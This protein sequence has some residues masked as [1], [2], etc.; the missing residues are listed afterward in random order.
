MAAFAAIVFIGLLRWSALTP[1]S[2]GRLMFPCIAAFG[3]AWVYGLGAL[4]R[5]LP[6][7]ATAALACLALVVPTTVLIPAYAK[8]A[9]GWSERLPAPV[10]AVYAGVIE[11]VE[12]G[13]ETTVEPGGEITLRL[14]WRVL[15][16]PAVNYSVFVHLVDDEGVIVA[17]RDMHPGQGSLATAE[18]PPGRLWS[19]RYSLRVSS[20]E[21]APRN[22]HWEIGLYDAASGA[23]AALTRVPGRDNAVAFGANRITPRNNPPVLLQYETGIVL[24]RY[25]LS[26]ST[27]APGEAL[28]VNLD[29]SAS[30]LV[31]G[32]V[33]ASVQLLDARSGKAA[34]SDMPPAGRSTSGWQAGENRADPRTLTIDPGTQSGA[35]RLMLVVYR[36][37][38]F[39]RVG[40]Y[41]ARGIYIGDQIELTRIWIK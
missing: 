34:Q 38:T 6:L 31:D 39:A 36:P 5:R 33:V 26:P 25:A 19:D 4:H 3:M 35:Y 27:I 16:P 9:P 40:G 41:D 37:G 13:G 11:L 30:S 21:R 18:L 20:L 10:G 7:F 15:T 1:A 23:R 12:A 29:W 2:Q 8:P 24:V 22:T 17:Q 28:Q 32:D 14:N